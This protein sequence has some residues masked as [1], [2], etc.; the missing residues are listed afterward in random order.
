M[1]LFITYITLYTIHRY[2]EVNILYPVEYHLLVTYFTAYSTHL[3]CY[4]VTV[5]CRVSLVCVSDTPIAVPSQNKNL[6]A[7]KKT[8][9]KREFA[10]SLHAEKSTHKLCFDKCFVTGIYTL[11]FLAPFKKKRQIM[12]FENSLILFNEDTLWVYCKTKYNWLPEYNICMATQQCKG[13]NANHI[14]GILFLLKFSIK[15][16]L[17]V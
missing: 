8:P 15:K 11:I 4:R 2:S 5:K 9:V 10:P 7:K 17:S 12:L 6:E 14:K 13:Y 16:C 1:L 3:L